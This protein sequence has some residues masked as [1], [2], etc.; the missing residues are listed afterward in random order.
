ME[1]CKNFW[2]IGHL[3]MGKAPGKS[4]ET[5]SK[6]RTE[7]RGQPDQTR[8]EKVGGDENATIAP[9]NRKKPYDGGHGR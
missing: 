5:K 6:E 3:T 4:L 7:N 2:L 9:D 1:G 8:E